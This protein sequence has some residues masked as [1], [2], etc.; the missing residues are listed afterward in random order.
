MEVLV[1]GV[2]ALIAIAFATAVSPRVGVAAPLILVALGVA[3]SLIPGMPAVEIEPE[4]ILAG[5]LPPL[6][7]AAGASIPATDFRREFRSIGALSVLLTIL[8]TVLV[9]V[10]VHALIPDLAWPWAFA[11]GAIVSPSDP[12]ATGIIKRLGVSPRVVGLLEGESL[13]N[14]A[15]ALVLLRGAIVA[16]ASA[17]T[18]WDIAWHFV[19]AMALAVAIGWL[20]GRVN[21]SVSARIKDPTANTVFTFTVPFL[22][23]IPAELLNASGLVAA[24]VA[25]LV[26]GNGAARRLSPQARQSDHQTWHAIE[27]MLEGA[28]YL[29]LG[30]ELLGTIEDVERDHEGVGHALGIAVVLLVGV[31]VVRA[32]FIAPLLWV[33]ARR[34][35]RARELQPHVE[36]VRE[37]LQDPERREAAGRRLGWRAR[38][39][40]R[41]AGSDHVERRL[42]RVQ[43]DLSY[44]VRGTLGPR[45]GAIM[46]WAGMRGVVTVAAAQTLPTDTPGRSLL[47][48]VAYLVAILSLV[49][50]GGTVAWVVRWVKPSMG[51]SPAERRAERERLDALMDEASARVRREFAS[52]EHHGRGGAQ[53]LAVIRAR[54]DALL[55]ARDV[56]TF[57]SPVLS[58]ALH[59]LDVEQIRLEL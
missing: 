43:A 40:H 29:I 9:G 20:V 33:Q 6:L 12:V 3:V 8:S 30:L 15:T 49:I 42:A 44:L 45:E 5:V 47:V 38:M 2:I 4:V 13:L 34:A 24:V 37:L 54:R 46:V 18:L 39:R 36:H 22:A 19:L 51:A 31:L 28:V 17:V 10:L 50:Q 35:R 27:L 32:A 14:D 16:A 48:L 59:E 1:I 21:L 25:G 26:T 55:D 11:I 7:Y 41:G 58:Q 56:G 23:S 52:Q 53:H 57:S